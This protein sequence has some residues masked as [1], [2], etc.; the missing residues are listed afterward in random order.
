MTTFTDSHGTSS[1]TTIPAEACIPGSVSFPSSDISSGGTLDFSCPTRWSYQGGF[2]PLGFRLNYGPKHRLQPFIDIHL[3]MLISAHDEP[4]Y[5][6]SRAN[7]AFA[8][9]TGLELYR[10]SN[11]SVSVE[12]RL[13]HF[14][15]ADSGYNNPGVDNQI[16][17]VA[18]SFGKT[19]K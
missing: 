1:Y 8:F 19:R 10:R 17:H 2:N 4:V 14:S 11:R 9:G 3:G 13:R 12:Y 5:F 15:N 18:Y 6:S 16:V 7:F